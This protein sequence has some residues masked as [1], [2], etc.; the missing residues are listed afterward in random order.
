MMRMHTI[1]YTTDFSD[2]SKAAGQMLF[3]PGGEEHAVKGIEDASVL[4]TILLHQTH[5]G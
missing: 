4:L 1:L 5:S 2:S 3:L